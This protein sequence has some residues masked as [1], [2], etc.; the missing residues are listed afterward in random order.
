MVYYSEDTR[1]NYIFDALGQP[2][3]RELITLLASSKTPVSVSDFAKKQGLSLQNA[4]KHVRV[5]E[6]AGLVRRKKIGVENYL[7]LNHKPLKQAEKW[8]EEHRIHWL[9]QLNTI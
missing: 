8:L 1:L 2:S 7:Y 6:R 9:R 4:G 5:L 3:R